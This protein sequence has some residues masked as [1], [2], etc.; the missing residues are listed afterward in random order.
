MEAISC[1]CLSLSDTS[2]SMQSLGPSML[3]QMALFHSF[4]NGCFL[5]VEFKSSLSIVDSRPLSDASFGNMFSQ[6]EILL[7]RSLMWEKS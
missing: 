3:L 4:F 6:F 5:I 7:T 2:L 1:I